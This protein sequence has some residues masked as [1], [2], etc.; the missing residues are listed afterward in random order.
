MLIGDKLM[1]FGTGVDEIGRDDNPIDPEFESNNVFE[2]GPGFY[3]SEDKSIANKYAMKAYSAKIRAMRKKINREG[4]K[5]DISNRDCKAYL[6]TFKVKFNELNTHSHIVI[7]DD[8]VRKEFIYNIVEKYKDNINFKINFTWT[9]GPLCGFK[10][11]NNVNPDNISNI[12]K[13]NIDSYLLESMGVNQLCIH[14]RLR[15]EEGG[16]MMY[17]NS[18]S[19]EKKEFIEGKDLYTRKEIEDSDGAREKRKTITESIPT[20][21]T[22]KRRVSGGDI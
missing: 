3:L 4:K 7:R 16:N 18:F 5:V 21:F 12:T 22:S 10:W 15:S 8:T 14:K 19:F 9:Y 17:L 13:E 1:Y 6:Y 2:F 11:D 20:S